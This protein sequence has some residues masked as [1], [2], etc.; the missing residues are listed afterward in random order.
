M[1]MVKQAGLLAFIALL[2]INP[3]QGLAAETIVDDAHGF[4]LSLPDGFVATPKTED[5]VPDLI[6]CFIADGSENNESS[7]L[8]FIQKL[9][10]R[11]GPERMRRESLPAD[12]R[13][14]LWTTLWQGYTVDVTEVL[15]EANGQ[16]VVTFN[17]QI[18]LEKAAIQVSL[19]GALERKAELKLLLDEVLAGLEGETNWDPQANELQSYVSEAPENYGAILLTLAVVFILVG[20][21]SL[22]LISRRTR[23]VVIWIAI[24]IY[25][26][27]MN[28]SSVRYR[29]V[30]ML[31]GTL[32]MLGTAGIILGIVDLISKRKPKGESPVEEESKDDSLESPASQSAP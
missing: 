23:G 7:I 2:A 15:E 14:D 21:L 5:P 9:P 4:T 18:P 31:S 12:F 28:L 30:I 6:H 13:G 11:I 22:W 24:L 20:L 10:F 32:K 27:G 26:A 1:K 25:G 8:L 3:A 16:D 19:F 29:E 17:V